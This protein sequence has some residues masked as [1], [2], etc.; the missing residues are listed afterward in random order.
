MLVTMASAK[1]I[2]VG[3]LVIKD[4]NIRATLPA[5]KVAAGYLTIRND[6]TEADR[7]LGGSMD[8]AA[9]VDVHEMKISDGV[10][11]MRPLKD[12]LIIGPGEMVVLK[13]GA[14][15]LMFMK[16]KEPMVE[17][18]T[19]LVVLK[20]EKAGEIEVNFPVGDVSASH[21]QHTH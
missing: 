20:F 19:R 17:G 12:G 5:A 18:Q 3:T 1:D 14:E 4:P 8:F 9:K 6:G 2:K 15:H 11:K 10:M 21:S 16:L 7:L 13:P